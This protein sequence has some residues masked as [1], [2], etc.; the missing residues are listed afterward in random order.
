MYKISPYD[1]MTVFLYFVF[2]G[3]FVS[4][5]EKNIFIHADANEQFSLSYIVKQDLYLP[6]RVI[7]GQSYNA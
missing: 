6:W 7:R 4:F 1:E 3:S 5:T 2:P